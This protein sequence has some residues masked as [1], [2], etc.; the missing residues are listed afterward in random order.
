MNRRIVIPGG[1]GAV[2]QLLARHFHRSGDRVTVLSR[3][4]LATAWRTAAWDGR[5]FDGSDIVINLAGRSV[6]CRYNAANRREIMSSRVDTT[7]EVGRAIAEAQR[8]PKVW[9]NASTATIYRHA[10]D[11]PMDEATGEIGGKEGGTMSTWKF[12]IDVATA[13]ERAFFEA[14]TPGVRK[15]A[16]RSALTAIPGMSW[17]GKLT[18]LAKFGLGGAAGAGN[19]FVSWIHETD[20][21]RAVEF[22]IEHE[23]IDGCVNLASPNPLPNVEFQRALREALGVS[24][25]PRLPEPLLR[26]GA[27]MIGSEAELILK[28][29]YVVPRRLLDAGFEFRFPT[30]PEAARELL[31]RPSGYGVALSSA[32]RR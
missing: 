1:S 27:A 9:I 29:R 31:W 32:T 13:W 8:T 11:R 23:E 12:S 6:D 3:R 4:P 5:E 19:Q 30:W 21:I 25:G 17:L 15:V 18:R 20:F 10:M 28:S 24:F 16:L 2:G 22:L 14:R 26:F 7:H